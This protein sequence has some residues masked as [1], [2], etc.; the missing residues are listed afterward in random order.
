MDGGRLVDVDGIVSD[1]GVDATWR[2][3]D[4]VAG[5]SSGRKRVALGIR[6]PPSPQPLMRYSRKLR[7]NSCTLRR[8]A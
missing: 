5:A 3:D 2:D 1:V 6:N 7:W 4:I 8:A